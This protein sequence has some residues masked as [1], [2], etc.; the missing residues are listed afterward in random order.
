ML[1]LERKSLVEEG[2][3]LTTENNP[4]CTLDLKSNS[5]KARSE[6]QLKYAQPHINPNP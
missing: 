2:R 5:K 3:G 4:F 1:G 6:N